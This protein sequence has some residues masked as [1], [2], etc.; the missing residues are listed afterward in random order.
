M[1]GVIGYA[2]FTKR[3]SLNKAIE[4][5]NH[6]GPD[7][8]GC[9]YF[10]GVALGNTR[11]AIIDL[12][13]KGH[14]PMFNKDKTLCITFNGEI[15]NF[16]E[17]KKLLE[18]KYDFTTHTDTEVIL[19]SYQEWGAK[20][21]EKLNGMFSF[22]IFDKTKN[23]L[24]GA[25]DRLGQKPLKYYLKYGKFIFASEIKAILSLLNFKPNIDNVAI[26]D[27]LT[28]Q[29]VPSPRTGFENIYKLPP[30]CYFIFK[31]NKLA[32]Y[33]YWS[34]DFNKKINL[35]TEDW[36]DLVFN[37]IERSVQS[38]L[39]SDVPVG[40]LLSGGLDSSIIVALMS[41]S[42][43][44]RINTFSI[45]FENEKFDETSYARIVSRIYNTKHTQLNITADD[46]IKN[47]NHIVDIY[48]EPIGDNSILPTMLVSKLA[49]TKVK[50]ALTG[51][52]GDENF[53][54]YDR[55]TFVNLSNYLSKLPPIIKDSSRLIYQS[56][57]TI[58]PNKQT[59]RANRFFSTLDDPFYRNYVN[60]NSFFINTV[61]HS[62][63]SRDFEEKVDG[64]D[65]FEIYRNIYDN[66]LDPL[67]NA[68]K[69][70]I[71]T[72][73]SDDLLYK[74]DSASMAYGLELRSPFLDYLLMERIAA[75]P[76][77]E[78]LKFT[79]KKKILKEMALRNNLLPKKIIYR[80]KQGFNIPQNKW[81][82]GELKSYILNKIMTSSMIERIFE[83]QNLKFYLDNYFNT[84]LGYDNNIFALLVL[85][86]WTD[87]YHD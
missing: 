8:R 85:A 28:L 39:I 13:I 44:R 21:L 6:R 68:L 30:G 24:F 65:T 81:F 15:Y 61:K 3:V 16:K 1:C 58:Y 67:D 69:I 19:Y 43:S 7:D 83:K 53:A 46:L 25:R 18:K 40:A 22:V 56:I 78:K 82:R 73:L 2:G 32:T 64:N 38:H 76:S 55:Y 23:L 51:D 79:T 50:V 71:N 14:Q 20:C 72:Y 26:D 49:S 57:F 9:Q 45:G 33:R 35:A 63:Y 5:I 86:L 84:N 70:D 27:F 54:G 60:Y 37:E 74:S 31:N 75:M 87:K 29:Y 4:T 12:S 11:L 48:D 36:Y 10:D 62:L 52:G 41:K 34:L 42:S 66:R 80:P 17:I 47:I 77:K 59:E